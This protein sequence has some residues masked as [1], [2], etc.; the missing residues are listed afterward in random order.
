M[1]I[2]H[3]LQDWKHSMF[4]YDA[5]LSFLIAKNSCYEYRGEDPMDATIPRSELARMEVCRCS[6]RY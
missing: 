5:S 1:R 3:A 2:M 4:Y 6:W